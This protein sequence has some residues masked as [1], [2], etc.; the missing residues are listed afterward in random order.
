MYIVY[1]HINKINNKKYFGITKRTAEQRW[2]KEG[3]NYK[4]SP[5]FYSAIQKYGWDNFEHIILFENLTKEE[6]CQKEQELIKKYRTNDREFGY[7]LTSGGDYFVMNKEV[8]IKISKA[9]KGNKNNLG[10]KHSEE[11]RKKISESLKGHIVTEEQRKH[12]SEAAKKRH[13]PCSEEKR[14]NLSQNY[15]NKKPVYCIE[16]DKIYE[17]VQECARQLH[18]HA[19][20]VSKVCRGKLNTTGGYH[21]CYYITQ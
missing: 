15:P 3:K 11:T 20:A 16:L 8:K 17:S 7:N 5:C 13:V 19:T 18:L 6:A 9:L 2:G 4:T 10:K 14:K 21:F 1:E 12:M